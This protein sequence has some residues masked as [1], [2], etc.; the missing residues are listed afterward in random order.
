MCGTF[1]KRRYNIAAIAVIRQNWKLLQKAQ[2]LTKIVELAML[3]L[4]ILVIAVDQFASR[5]IAN[6]NTKKHRRPKLAPV[7]E[8]AMDV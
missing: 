5:N 6:P 7:F 2:G 4:V 8:M 3:A 1:T